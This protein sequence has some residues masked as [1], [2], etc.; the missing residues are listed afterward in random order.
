MKTR[1]VD[2]KTW[3]FG[4]GGL[5]PFFQDY[6][7]RRIREVFEADNRRLRLVLIEFNP[8]QTTSTRWRRAVAGIDSYLTLLAS[9]Q[10]LLEIA[11][12]DPERG[13]LLYNIKYFRDNVSAE[14]ITTF[15]GQPFQDPRQRSDKP[16]L[17][18]TSQARFDEISG[19]LG[20]RF[21]EEYPDWDGSQWNYDW[22][23]AGTVP[24]ER[25]ADTVA[26]FPEYFDLMQMRNDLI[27]IPERC[28]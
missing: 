11:L 13:A 25:P 22:Q 23:G 27:R 17:D 2:T 15:F 26:M 21:N 8:F 16:G 4:F 7:S 6:L 24:W 19:I 3:N 5:N 9:D 28:F 12:D 18:E 20:D 14:V 10:E 1:G